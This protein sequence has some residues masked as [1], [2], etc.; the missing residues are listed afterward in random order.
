MAGLHGRRCLPLPLLFL[1]L[2]GVSPTVPSSDVTVVG[3]GSAVDVQLMADVLLMY[4]F[5]QPNVSVEY[6]GLDSPRG[7]CRIMSASKFCNSSDVEPPLA[8]D[9]A[10]IDEVVPTDQQY[11]EV[12][13]LQ[14]YPLMANSVVAIFNLGAPRT[15]V[16]SMPILAGI[17]R[18]NVTRWDDPQ[19]TTLNP[20]FASWGVPQGQPIEVVVR[21]EDSAVSQLFRAA[22]RGHDGF[23]NATGPATG[24]S[25]GSARPTAVATNQGVLSYV[26][27]TPYTIGYTTMGEGLANG[28]GVASLLRS[29]GHV[30]A[31]SQEAVGYALLEL[32]GR[33]GLDDTDPSRLTASLSNAANPLAWPIVGYSY[34]AIRKS[35]LRPGATCSSFTAL[36]HFLKWFIDSTVA[37][38]I[39]QR[40]TFS[41]LP[42]LLSQVVLQRLDQ[43]DQ[44]NNESA[45]SLPSL[46]LYSVA[47]AAIVQVVQPILEDYSSLESVPMQLNVSDD[48]AAFPTA[49]FPLQLSAGRP[50]QLSGSSTLIFGGIAIVAISQVDAVLDVPTL[51]RILD[52]TITTWLD[53]AL[54]S[55]N[56]T[57]LFT[58][59]GV[60]V[61][62]ASQPILLLREPVATSAAVDELLRAAYPP[63]SGRAVRQAPAFSAVALR[64]ALLAYPFSLALTTLSGVLPSG[65]RLLR[66]QR[67]NGPI[68]APTVQSVAACA[69]PD[70]FDPTTGDMRLS[71]SASPACYPLACPVY[72]T[73]PPP[74]CDWSQD[75]AQAV[76]VHFAQ[77]RFK[78]S[79][80]AV[81]AAAYLAT[82]DSVAPVAVFNAR[83]LTSL[84][85]SP[86]AGSWTAV[87]VG[88]GVGGG[89][90]VVAVIVALVVALRW[91]QRDL[92]RAPT[93]P[94]RP[95]CV[96]FTDIESS[97]VLWAKAPVEMAAAL[98]EHHAL[99]RDLVRQFRLY[100]VK[101]IGDSFMCVTP[102]CRQALDFALELQARFH[103]HD[104]G[105]AALDDVYRELAAAGPGAPKLAQE[106]SLWN[107]LRVRVGVHYGVGQI[108][109]DPVARGYDYYGTVVNCAARV[110]EVCHGGQ[111]AVTEVVQEQLPSEDLAAGI[112]TDLGQQ[113]LRGLQPMRLLQVLPVGPLSQRQFPPLRQPH[114]TLTER[115]AASPD[116][117]PDSPSQP[118]TSPVSFS[119]EGH[120]LV[121][122]G[123]IT[124]PELQLRYTHAIS[125][126]R[127]LLCTQTP[128]FRN[129]VLSGLCGRLKVR[130]IGNTGPQL[131][132]TLHR[133]V[134]RILPA[135]TLIMPTS[136]EDADGSIAPGG[137]RL[138]SGAS[139]LSP[140]ASASFLPV[141]P[142]TLPGQL[143]QED[144]P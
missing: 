25:W 22:L 8:I 5:V 128:T 12:P 15:L 3:A 23:A 75:S 83:V 31:P 45:P 37:A 58:A 11:A 63:Y 99:I 73:L 20:S 59:A 86:A 35:T 120:P 70:G 124:A 90:F 141:V 140:D 34:A 109:F 138:R 102:D 55:L 28:L 74:T 105:T 112:W 46:K 96:L 104:W 49:L 33:F 44:C 143:P 54:R 71:A 41:P 100:E 115:G 78:A 13:D 64:S 27:A 126:L 50:S 123:F 122:R 137:R 87:A 131:H 6:T 67:P 57:G 82:F 17:F 61:T 19:I 114:G 56:P 110:M 24:M 133:L 69:S 66:L 68:V 98:Q 72:L 4:S 62:N 43:D 14:L 134:L 103:A 47:P 139:L 107:G 29:T 92:R 26:M 36:M 132:A 113:P 21:R 52:G 30:V 9:F 10:L 91:G 60:P 93:D 101:T 88:A 127:V 1:L 119:P 85:C 16:L 129:E 89:G 135:L 116:P 144:A 121:L 32:G 65:L 117:P 53:P 76:A 18:G 95:F 40:H 118:L 2:C 108:K 79:I 80:S 97:T 51:A 130:H 48:P 111:T 77:W 125:A 94:G 142:F 7:L 39:V 38:R 84:S 136:P 81:L 106:P 42:V